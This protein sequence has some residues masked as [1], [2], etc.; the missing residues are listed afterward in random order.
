MIKN[1][2]KNT[3][4]LKYFKNTFWLLSEKTLRLFV[5]VF[6]GAWVAR[7]LGPDRY[8]LLSYSISFVGLFSVLASFGLDNILVREL[9]KNKYKE[10]VLLGTSLLLKLIGSV[11]VILLLIISI[12]LVSNDA[13]TNTLVLIIGSATIFQ[14]FNIIDLFF[15]SKTLSRFMVYANI[16]S[17]LISSLL[18]I[19]FISINAPLIY[20]AY[21]ILFDNLILALGFIY[22]FLIIYSKDKSLKFFFNYFKF[23]FNVAINLLK[24]SWPLIFSGLLISIYMKIDK[25][26]IKEFLGNEAVGEYSVA[27]LISE[28]WYFI[29]L[30]IGGSLYPAIIRAKNI[31]KDLYLKRLQNLYDLMVWLGIIIA[32]PVMLMSDYIIDILYG[33]EF[34]NAADVLTIHIWTGVFVFLGIAFGYYLHIENY[35]KKYLFKSFL[36][37]TSNI[38]LNYYL[39]PIYGISGAAASTL[40]GQFICNYL[41]DFLDKDLHQQ[42]K[43][44]T[45]SFFPIHLFKWTKI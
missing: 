14:S 4:F 16:F 2:Y 22:F 23:D 42:L 9:V 30:M 27:A 6:V 18:K 28:L 37:A 20:F 44:K 32:L 7:Y 33:Q 11:I 17:L 38:S 40:L 3:G 24:D 31:S 19:F 5:G 34:S 35:N 8:G 45:K 1:L 25:I 36:G 15:Q 13:S 29:P 41:T 10:G 39:I 21:I 26:M 12:N 43:M